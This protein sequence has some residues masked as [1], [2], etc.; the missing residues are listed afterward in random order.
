MPAARVT[1][2]R[3]VARYVRRRRIV[4]AIRASAFAFAAVTAWCLLACIVDRFAE[5]NRAIRVIDVSIAIIAGLILLRPAA[6]LLRRRFD[7]VAAAAEIERRYPALSGRLTTAV[8]PPVGGTSTQM[9][10]VV[11]DQAAAALPE[12]IPVPWRPLAV[13]LLAMILISAAVAASLRSPRLDMRELARRLIHPMTVLPPVTATHLSMTPTPPSVPVGDPLKI[14]CSAIPVDPAT[15]V[16][17][18]SDDAGRTWGGWPMVADPAVLGKF[19]YTWTAV[20]TDLRF[21]IT[22]GDSTGPVT[23]VA[24][25]AKPVILEFRSRI[26]P[27][28]YLHRPAVNVTSGDGAIDAVDGSVVTTD[29]ICSRPVWRLQMTANGRQSDI[30]PTANPSVVRWQITIHGDQKIDLRAM[31]VDGQLSEPRPV[32]IRGQPDHPPSV[33][34]IEPVEV[35]L[36]A[37]TGTADAGFDARDDFGLAS[38][39]TD[40]RVNQRRPQLLFKP[41]DGTRQSV[42]VDDAVDLK[43]LK[44]MPGDVVTI[45]LRARDG[46]DQTTGSELHYLLVVP[47]APD[48]KDAR[49]R[50]DLEAALDWI[51]RAAIDVTAA[52]NVRVCLT[53]AAADSPTKSW[54]SFLMSLAGKP[55]LSVKGDVKTL[56]DA[57]RADEL[58]RLQVAVD[59]LDGRSA[60]VR[61]SAEHRA[62]RERIVARISAEAAKL[63]VDL[64]SP[65]AADKLGDIE[66]AADDL[67]SAHPQTIATPIPGSAAIKA[68][69]PPAVPAAGRR[70]GDPDVPGYEDAVKLYFDRLKGAAGR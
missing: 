54:A 14:T 18:V 12:R 38:V 57:D 43:P 30:T 67:V 64:S 68:P 48:P 22:A 51:D 24:A 41:F 59:W 65:E 31:G 45:R 63:G 20:A 16:L 32:Q 26:E 39:A 46:L 19:S 4:A 61:N 62:V 5:F 44:L 11:T 35:A 29:V 8:S 66:Q 58:N 52:G 47:N 28:K 25:S 36:A 10:A 40:I 21:F 70:A 60:V 17:H 23:T 1:I 56:L 33:R 13:P 53:R 55:A 49:R 50:A 7:A 34:F 27:P 9:L 37:S 6:R 15:V 3:T 69:R 2:D 42:T